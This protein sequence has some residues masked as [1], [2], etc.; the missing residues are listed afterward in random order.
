MRLSRRFTILTVALLALNVSLWIVP[1]GMALRQSIINRLLGPTM[2]RAEV[3]VQSGANGA[4]DFRIDRGVV[5]AASTAEITLRERDGAVETIPLAATTQLRGV[6]RVRLASLA[7]QPTQVVV[8]RR[9]NEAAL[10]LD[11]EGVPVGGG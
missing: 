4:Q 6:R 7:R 3:V 11:V 2:I 8:V 9:T 10:S 1:S 5:T